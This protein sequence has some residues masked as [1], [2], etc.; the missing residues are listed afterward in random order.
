MLTVPRAL[1]PLLGPSVGSA[2]VA[3]AAVAS[4]IAYLL[5]SKAV[6]M[7]VG[8]WAYLQ[9][10]IEQVAASPSARTLAF[11]FSPSALAVV[12]FGV[13]VASCVTVGALVAATMRGSRGAVPMAW[14]SALAAAV[15]PTLVIATVRWPD[16]GG[17]VTNT[18]IC[19]AQLVLVAVVWVWWRRAHAL[20][21]GP[22][23]RA[24]FEP[25]EAPRWVR[26]FVVIAACYALTVLLNG[27]TGI[28]GYDSFS[29]HLAVPD[30]WLK[31]GRLER[32]IPDEI[33]TF[34][35][36]N[37]EL[38]VRWTLSLGTDRLAFLL[39]FGSSVAAVWVIYRIALELGQSRTAARISAMGAASL[40][41]LA[42]QSMVV[43]SDSFTALCLLLATWLLLVWARDGATDDRLTCGFGIAL[44][45]AL[46]AKYSAGPPAIVLGLAWLWCMWRESFRPDAGGVDLLNWRRFG[47]SLAILVLS[48]LPA[49]AYWYLR[50]TI[51]Q[52]NPLFPLSIAGLPGINLDALL[53]NAPGPASAWER[54]TFPW[55]ETGHIAGYETGLGPLFAAVAL[56]AVFA[57]PLGRFRE[58]SGQRMLWLILLGAF[59]AWWRTGVI[60]P[61]YGLFPLL[62]SYVFIGELW[63]LFAS[64]LLGVVI[65]VAVS[66]TML[67]VGHEMLGGAAYI[68][69]M[70]DPKPSVPAIIDQLPPSRILN[71][72]GQPSGYYAKGSD[73]RH[74]V[75]NL[76]KIVTLDDV[77]RLAPDYLLLPQSLEQ[78]FV[79]PLGLQFMGR[80]E[81][82]G[83]ASTSLWRVTAP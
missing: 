36:G 81:K 73:S 79:A 29:N 23:D 71:V 9:S 58:S 60:V 63:T 83:Q 19:L 76:F 18:T 72:A 25:T 22:L 69:L 20:E 28:Y 74:R 65:G 7:M 35:P 78:E 64:R 82:A 44:G 57:A 13:F 67:S 15:V 54:L 11:E 50:N 43:Y 21:R 33:V 46:G 68:E 52:H 17:S 42:Y 80:W 77:R 45:L 5:S 34:Y 48:V 40:Q 3:L 75:F 30:R 51:E 39:S 61:R 24:P 4:L 47:R 38:L 55:T 59:A 56:V 6:N 14:V 32:G 41:V 2:L 12:T 62:L 49:M 31:L 10:V 26:L 37:F 53:A 1:R 8:G 16:G 66:A 27:F 70:F